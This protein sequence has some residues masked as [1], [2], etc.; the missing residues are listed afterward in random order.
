MNATKQTDPKR[1]KSME[2]MLAVMAVDAAVLL[3]FLL[4]LAIEVA[5][6]DAVLVLMRRHIDARRKQ[7]ELHVVALPA[8]RGRMSR[9]A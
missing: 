4:A 1:K 5:L 2:S 6:I 9:R 7:E 8:P 3:S